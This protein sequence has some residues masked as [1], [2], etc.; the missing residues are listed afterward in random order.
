MALVAQVGDVHCWGDG[1]QLRHRD[2][3]G[4][5][6]VIALKSKGISAV[7][8]GGVGA[9]GNSFARSIWC[10]HLHRSIGRAARYRDRTGF[11]PVGVVRRHGQAGQLYRT[12]ALFQ[13]N[14][15]AVVVGHAIVVGS[16]GM[17]IPC[18][19][20]L[21]GGDGTATGI[22]KQLPADHS[23][24]IRFHAPRIFQLR[25]IGSG[26]R[27][28]KRAVDVGD[29]AYRDRGRVSAIA[30]RGTRIAVRDG[31]AGGCASIL[32]HVLDI[33]GVS[34]GFHRQRAAGCI[35][36]R[37]GKIQHIGVCAAG[38]GECP[39]VGHDLHAAQIGAFRAV[40]DFVKHQRHGDGV[41]GQVAAVC[42]RG[43]TKE[44]GLL[45]V[46]ILQIVRDFLGGPFITVAAATSKA[47]GQFFCTYRE[48]DIPVALV[49]IFFAPG[50]CFQIRN[51]A[52][53]IRKCIACVCA[54]LSISS[55]PKDR[56]INGAVHGTFPSSL[57]RIMAQVDALSGGNL[58]M[59]IA[60]IYF[61]RLK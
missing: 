41:A 9:A 21:P 4:N 24:F 1:I 11:C 55:V 28:S 17:E 60:V 49:S 32:R 15:P 47:N 34:D 57:I 6:V 13:R 22:G 19:A 33:F 36:Y 29:L 58:D 44:L 50:F 40:H 12:A 16:A 26:N 37:T 52:I 2:H 42:H 20:G 27:A 51:A 48:L 3:F 54:I 53:Q 7:L 30:Q 38:V 61:F 45:G 59:L 35:R 8:G 18:T 46:Q 23:F 56:S 14:R 43:N 5:G 39:P 10:F 31:A 25:R